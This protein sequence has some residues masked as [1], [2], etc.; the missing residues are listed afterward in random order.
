MTLNEIFNQKM[1]AYGR[2][3]SN[4]LRQNMIFLSPYNPQD[5]PELLF[6]C[7]AYCQ[8][9]TIIAN[10]KYTDE[11]LLMNV[12]N[13]LTD[14]AYTNAILTIGIKNLTPTKCDSTWARL[15]RQH[16]NAALLQVP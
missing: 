12:I 5:P 11:Q 15:S 3:T 8:E 10:V 6:K 2:P 1:E 13:L 14:V 4:A 16:I 9:V 7:C